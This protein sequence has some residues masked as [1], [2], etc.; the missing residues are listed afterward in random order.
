MGFR[1]DGKKANSWAI[2][3]KVNG[4][5]INNSHLPSLFLETEDEWIN[6]LIHGY[7]E[8]FVAISNPLAWFKLEEMSTEHLAAVSKLVEA[9]PGGTDMHVAQLSSY[10]KESRYFVP[11]CARISVTLWQSVS[12]VR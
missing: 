12:K 7:Y 10:A 4:E 5:D 9:Y 2:W 6:F 3:L 11:T 1:R 8:S